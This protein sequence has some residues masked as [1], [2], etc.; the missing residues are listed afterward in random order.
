MWV[1][2]QMQKLLTFF[3]KN[4][5]IYPIFNDQR[6]NSQLTSDIVNFEQLGGGWSGGAK[7][8]CILHH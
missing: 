4:I 7:V 5:S 1:A 3:S 8:L 2:L 6:F